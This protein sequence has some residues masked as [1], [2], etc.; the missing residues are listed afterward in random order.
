M[1]LIK[2]DYVCG[3]C[4]R[5]TTSAT[6]PSGASRFFGGV[7]KF[8]LSASV[9]FF[10][11]LALVFSFG[12]FSNFLLCF[13]ILAGLMLGCGLAGIFFFDQVLEKGFGFFSETF[14]I[15]DQGKIDK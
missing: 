9:G 5:V 2:G 14:G 8:M 6:P 13:L 10:V 4:V 12:L 11:W 3:D 15:D 1:T 7:A